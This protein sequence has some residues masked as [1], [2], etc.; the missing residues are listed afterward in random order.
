MSP[1]QLVRAAR[2]LIALLSDSDA[3]VRDQSRQGLIRISGGV[4]FDP[5]DGALSDGS[6]EAR[7][8]HEIERWKRYWDQIELLR[9]FEPRAKSLLKMA[10]TLDERGSPELAL[11]YYLQI[12]RDYP[13]TSAAVAAKLRVSHEA[14]ALPDERT[15][16]TNGGT[17]P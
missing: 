14:S 8:R 2:A 13:Q 10:E 7:P 9:L 3:K 4:K 16:N 1:R 17:G 12:V 5:S 11:R 6:A 15:G